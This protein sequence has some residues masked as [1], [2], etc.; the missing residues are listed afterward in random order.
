MDF[1]YK[2]N[3]IKLLDGVNIQNTITS[4]LLICF[5]VLKEE[6]DHIRAAALLPSSSLLA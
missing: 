2:I 1:N 4:S 5:G 6:C 3:S